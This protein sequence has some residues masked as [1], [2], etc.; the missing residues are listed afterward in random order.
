[1]WPRRK[2]CTF[3]KAPRLGQS[4]TL[5]VYPYKMVGPSHQCRETAQVDKVLAR[6]I[7][8]FILAEKDL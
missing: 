1:M 6:D 4:N 8:E 2:E 7:E 5:Y 3:Q